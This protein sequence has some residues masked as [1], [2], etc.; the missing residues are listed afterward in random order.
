[1]NI[2]RVSHAA[3]GLLIRAPV[4]GHSPFRTVLDFQVHL[5]EDAGKATV[6]RLRHGH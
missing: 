3:L 1:M 6:R 5:R 4:G 2:N